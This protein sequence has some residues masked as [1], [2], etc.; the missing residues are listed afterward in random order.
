[1]QFEGR[2]RS[3]QSLN[4]I[5][6]IDVLFFMIMF[7]ML[8]S[9]FVREKSLPVDLPQARSGTTE[10]VTERVEITVTQK[11]E[12]LLHEHIVEPGA[13]EA[14]L[15]EELSRREDKTVRVR[16]D[17]SAA[18]EKFVGVLDTAHRAGASGVD[19]ITEQP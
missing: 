4:I 2:R 10:R 14:M 8:T 15:R 17:K 5:P 3:G 18:L 13:L 11:G 9:H 1:M 19:I 6:L 12:V 16:G 7:F